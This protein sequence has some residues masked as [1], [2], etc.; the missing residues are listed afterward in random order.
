MISLPGLN[1]GNEPLF[2]LG[3]GYL[4]ASIRND[5]PALAVHYQ[6]IEH[7]MHQLT[8]I[9]ADFHPDII[10]LTC[11]SFNRGNVRN[12][13]DWLRKNYPEKKIVLGGVHVSFLPEQALRNYG[14][15]FVVIGEGELTLRELCNAIDGLMPVSDV[16][17]IAYLDNGKITITAPRETVKNLDELPMPDYSFAKDLMKESGMGFVISSRGCPVRCSFCSTGTYWGQ[18]V[19][20]NSPKRVVDEIQSL[21]EKYGVKKIFF[22]DDTFNLNPLRVKEICTEITSRN[23]SIEWGVSCRVHPVSQEMIDMMVEAGCRHICWGIESGSAEMLTKI[24]K[25]ISLE[26]IRHAFRLCEKHLGIISVGAFMMVG[27]KG[28]TAA[29]IAESCSF[30][31]SLKLTDQPSTSILYILPGTKLY[32]ELL[33]LIPDLDRY[34]VESDRVFSYTAEHPLEQLCQWTEKVSQSGNIV[35]YNRK[36]HF[37]NNVLFGAIPRP[38]PPN[39]SFLHSKLNNIIPAEIRDDELYQLIKKL[40]AESCIE[41]VLEIGSSSGD[42]STEAFVM[43]LQ[44]NPYHPKL[45]CLEVS[46]NRFAQLKQR[47]KD[48]SFVNCYNASSVSISD[49]PSEREIELFYRWIPSALND[50][51]LEKVLAWLSQDIEYISSSGVPQNGIQRIKQENGIEYFGMVLIDGSEFTGLAELNEVY[52]ATH[53][54]LDDINGFKNRNNY[55]LLK[56]DPNYQLVHDNWDLRNG[57]AVFKKI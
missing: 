46:K 55:Q 20:V 26:Q 47:Y 40:A 34:W 54:I 56:E 25:K 1:T 30:I 10:A 18:K 31:N 41:S 6:L 57:F 45:Y 2:P 19:R 33:T 14:A 42:G 8:E 50:Y 38:N 9:I 22:H 5:R 3:I 32:K 17:G 28:E 36:N 29:T 23:V 13:C 16:N 48:S 51:P 15:D 43:G 44:E 11:T 7:A 24:E 52:G 27:N 35:P 49:F 12:A 4:L 53:I 21:V 39:I 37:W